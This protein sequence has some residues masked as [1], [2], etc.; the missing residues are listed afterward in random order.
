MLSPAT[1]IDIIQPA[2][3]KLTSL[4]IINIAPYLNEND[5]AG[6]LSTSAAL[7]AACLE[8]GFF[9]LDISQFIDPSEP[10]ELTKLA[11]EFFALPQGEKDKIG[12]A[13]QDHARGARLQLWCRL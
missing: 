6:R 7:H 10:E 3:P 13:N 2:L 4:P 8:Y 5:K 1:A 9:Y 11:R 12:M